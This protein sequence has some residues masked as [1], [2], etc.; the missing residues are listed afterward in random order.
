MGQKVM[1]RTCPA[2]RRTALDRPRGG[3]AVIIVLATSW[4]SSLF[5][6]IPGSGLR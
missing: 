1:G 4:L 6:G 3:V 2:S 5:C